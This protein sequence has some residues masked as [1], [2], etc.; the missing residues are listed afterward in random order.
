MTAPLRW[1]GPAD[2]G[3]DEG[4]DDELKPHA[5]LNQTGLRHKQAG[6]PDTHIK[7]R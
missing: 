5:W 7:D 6:D 4:D 1:R 3:S 2:H